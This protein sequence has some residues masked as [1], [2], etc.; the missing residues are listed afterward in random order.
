MDDEAAEAAEEEQLLQNRWPH[1]LI[2]FV[3]DDVAKP[4]T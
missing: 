2:I 1:Y 4:L 3:F